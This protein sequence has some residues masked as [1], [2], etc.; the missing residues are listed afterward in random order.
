MAKDRA[1]HEVSPDLRMV[2]TF[3]R[4]RGHNRS[5]KKGHTPPGVAPSAYSANMC[6]L[7]RANVRSRPK[8]YTVSN[9]PG[10]AVRPV[11]ATRIG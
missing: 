8:R 2:C 9:S 5:E 7:R 1:I 11:T 10:L 3:W 6:G 4:R